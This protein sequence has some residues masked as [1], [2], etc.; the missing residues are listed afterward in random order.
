MPKITQLKR[1]ILSIELLM[2]ADQDEDWASLDLQDLETVV[3]Y[4]NM[5]VV[6]LKVASTS[7]I[8]GEAACAA[9]CKEHGTDLE[10]FLDDDD[11]DDDGAT[12]G[13]ADVDHEE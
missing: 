6:G 10:S 7:V 1:V 4:G 5:S 12:E 8:I 11:D 9:A 2:R 3:D 13:D